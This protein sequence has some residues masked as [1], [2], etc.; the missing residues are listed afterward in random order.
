MSIFSSFDNYQQ[1]IDYQ[2]GNMVPGRDYPITF[3]GNEQVGYYEGDIQFRFDITATTFPIKLSDDNLALKK[4]KS[5]T[6]TWSDFHK[7]GTYN[8]ELLQSGAV[9]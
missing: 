4:G 7:S 5:F 9:V 1:A 3:D 6:I 8:I 2:V